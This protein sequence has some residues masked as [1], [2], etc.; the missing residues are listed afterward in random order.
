M[1]KNTPKSYGIILNK[2]VQYVHFDR[3]SWRYFFY[4][5]CV[6]GD[7]LVFDHRWVNFCSKNTGSKN[8]LN[9]HTSIFRRCQ[10]GPHT[11]GYEHPC[12]KKWGPYE[13][14]I[15]GPK[16]VFLRPKKTPTYYAYPCSSHDREKLSKE[17]STL[18]A[19][20]ASGSPHPCFPYGIFCYQWRLE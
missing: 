15:L 8:R 5:N 16:S 7:F 4:Y 2:Y 19:F 18:L 11:E 20:W 13:K 12:A 10:N 14:L 9:D 1:G 17:K 3:D 6:N